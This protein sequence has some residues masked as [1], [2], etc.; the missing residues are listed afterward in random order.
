MAEQLF[1]IP[2]GK[3][4]PRTEFFLIERLGPDVW[5]AADALSDSAR[6]LPK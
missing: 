3:F 6:G 1:L 5:S 4:L 2:K